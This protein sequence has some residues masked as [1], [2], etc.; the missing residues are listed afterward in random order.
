MAF[1]IILVVF[2]MI[3][4]GAIGYFLAYLKNEKEELRRKSNAKSGKSGWYAY[5]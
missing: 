1:I 3:M 4:S 2:G 5:C